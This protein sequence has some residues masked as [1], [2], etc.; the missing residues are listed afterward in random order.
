V[1]AK[2][3]GLEHIK[4]KKHGDSL[5]LFSVEGG[6]RWNHARLTSLGRDVWGLSLGMSSGRWE[7]TPFVGTM[8]EVTATLF[9]NFTGYLEG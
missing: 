3:P 6:Q 2:Q 7:R 8:K 1:V 4:V 5:I 9:E